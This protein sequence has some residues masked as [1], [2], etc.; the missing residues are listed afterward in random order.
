MR[1]RNHPG[2]CILR[3]L[4]VTGHTVLIFPVFANWLGFLS[5]HCLLGT[6]HTCNNRTMVP[7]FFFLSLL[8]ILLG[9]TSSALRWG[10][11]RTTMCV[12]WHATLN[13]LKL[14]RVHLLYS[15]VNLY[16]CLS[17]VKEMGLASGGQG[18]LHTVLDA[19]R[20]SFFPH[21]VWGMCQGS[22]TWQ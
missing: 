20:P 5:I 11:L 8:K 6:H 16:L 1:L 7:F 12:C 2:Q 9:R 22:L 18:S 17:P 13:G 14:E 21:A 4:M 10:G 3:R 15:A 19:S